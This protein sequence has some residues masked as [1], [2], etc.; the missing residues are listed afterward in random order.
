M[1]FIKMCVYEQM[2]VMSSWGLCMTLVGSEGRRR[3]REDDEEEALKRKQLQEEHLSKVSPTGSSPEEMVIK[4][5]TCPVFVLNRPFNTQI[6]GGGSSLV[7][8]FISCDKMV[9]TCSVTWNR[10]DCVFR[11][12]LVWESSFSRKR[13]KKSRSGSVTHAASLLSAT[14]PS[15]QTVTQVRS[16]LISPHGLCLVSPAGRSPVS[17]MSGSAGQMCD[18]RVFH[19]R[20]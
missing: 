9:F 12:S 4:D 15:R 8:P 7:L 17:F 20:V 3:S 2:Q 6:G 18:L 16:S 5:V 14:T 10:F 11:F 19:H 1:C 13:W